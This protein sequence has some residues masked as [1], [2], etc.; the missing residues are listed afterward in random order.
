MND[1]QNRQDSIVS[2]IAPARQASHLESAPTRNSFQGYGSGSWNQISAPTS[3]VSDSKAMRP[4]TSESHV[5]RV[6][7]DR[8][9]RFAYLRPVFK[10]LADI[11]SSNITSRG[12]SHCRSHHPHLNANIEDC[13]LSYL[14]LII[15][16]G[17]LRVVL[18]KL[19]ESQGLAANRWRAVSHA[20][21]MHM[22]MRPQSD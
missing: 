14:R 12:S 13:L 11:W 10:H 2:N 1:C 3:P 15:S 16:D 21:D 6:R 7:E 22:L 4:D 8:E 9:A 18:T 19:V 5:Y 20:H 17:S